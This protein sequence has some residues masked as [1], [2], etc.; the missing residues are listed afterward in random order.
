MA[1]K[2]AGISCCSAIAIPGPCVGAARQR[3]R[4]IADLG[5]G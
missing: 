3:E 1:G 4:V 2:C 5:R